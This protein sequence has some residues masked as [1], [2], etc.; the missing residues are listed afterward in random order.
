L[1]LH[2][3]IALVFLVLLLSVGGQVHP[4]SRSTNWQTL[5]SLS[6]VA[7]SLEEEIEELNR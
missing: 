6:A 1:I 7:A 2:I 4:H 5:E 3:L